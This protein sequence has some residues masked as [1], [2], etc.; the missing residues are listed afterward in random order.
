MIRHL[1]IE[2]YKSIRTA[3]IPLGP[4]RILIGPNAAGKSNVIDTLRLL[5]EA[6]REDVETA[7]TRR[8]DL[9]EV[10]FLAA[11]ENQ[12]TFE[13]S[14]DY[15]VPDPSV[16]TSRS[17]MTYRVQVGERHGRPGV[18]LE[19]LRIK[20]VRGE[21]GRSKIWFSAKWGKGQA[22]RDTKTLAREPF[23]TGDPGV[24]ALKALGFLDAYPRIR[25]LRR[26]IEGWRFLTVDLARIREPQRDRRDT[27]LAPDAANL[28]NVLRTL[29]GTDR[30]C[31]DAILESVHS[32]LTQVEDISTNVDRGRVIL[33]LRERG[34]PRPLEALSLSDGTLRILAIVTALQTMPEHGLLCVE[35][36]EHGVHPLVFG[37]LLDL[38]RERCPSDGSRQTL[39]TTHSPDLI[40]GAEPEEVIPLERA[41][42]GSTQI[43]PLD[44]TQLRRWMED[45]RLGELW[46][47][48]QIGGVP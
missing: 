45:F 7:V 40:D 48:R 18:S 41:G 20:R 3:L 35:E 11:P 28:A 46:R 36:P 15:F 6:V 30:A 47:M 19:E 44:A 34:M 22:L 32:L 17:D 23:D 31:Y 2:R 10:V 16:P 26:F 42:D 12:Q 25:A 33:L 8:G 1:Q 14:L 43:H 38:V 21:R 27:E 24:L 5:S 4:L 37:P 39:L 9:K 13:I 29:E